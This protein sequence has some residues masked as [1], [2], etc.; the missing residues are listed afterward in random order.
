MGGRTVKNVLGNGGG[1]LLG[2]GC[3][4]EQEGRQHTSE[5]KAVGGQEAYPLKRSL[6]VDT[7]ALNGTQKNKPTTGGRYLAGTF[8]GHISESRRTKKTGLE[9]VKE[10]TRAAHGVP[11]KGNTSRVGL[12]LLPMKVNNPLGK[13]KLTRQSFYW[14]TCELVTQR[15]LFEK[16]QCRRRN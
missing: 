6:E 10:K 1:H 16:G 5:P 14:S 9:L 13:R 4:I 8:K 12:R 3:R 2:G 11:I 7:K 15:I